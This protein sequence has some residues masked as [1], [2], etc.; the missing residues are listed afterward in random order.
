MGSIQELWVVSGN[1]G[2]NIWIL[3]T[4]VEIMDNSQ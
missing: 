2:A 3:W 4:V 1:Y